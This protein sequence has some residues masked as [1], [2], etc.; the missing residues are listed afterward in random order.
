MKRWI[1]LILALVMVL[2]MVGCG[3]SAKEPEP[4]AT[5]EPTARE[6]LNEK[7]EQLYNSL[8][9]I[10]TADFYEPAQIR[11][12][13]IG[14]Y[15]ARSKYTDSDVLYGPD[16]VIVRLQG[17]NR[18]GGTLN[19]YY[20][21]VLVGAKNTSEYGSTMK[22]LY[23]AKRLNAILNGEDSSKYEAKEL[24]YS[25]EIGDYV[26]LQDD[27]SFEASADDFNIGNVNRALKEY[28]EEM[29]F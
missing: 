29:G 25:G 5:P 24:D 3:E 14:D 15:H 13:E 16:T 20:K 21:I 28:W 22:D 11:V 8:I 12:M 4:T 27:Y 18:V 7:E 2:G 1:A 9:K 17:E 26:E 19:H 6:M 10:T 23:A